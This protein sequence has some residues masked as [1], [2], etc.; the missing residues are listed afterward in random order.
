MY[1]HYKPI[2]NKN[3]ILVIIYNLHEILCLKKILKYECELI[4]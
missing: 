2:C 3:L 4:V 1:K